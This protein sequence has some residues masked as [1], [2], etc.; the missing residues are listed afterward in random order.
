MEKQGQSDVTE[1]GGSDLTL[2]VR[3]QQVEWVAMS[4][5][6]TVPCNGKSSSKCTAL[7]GSYRG[8]D[9]TGVLGD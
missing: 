7:I 4:V 9:F 2:E 1:R 6:S 8:M 3:W 5:T